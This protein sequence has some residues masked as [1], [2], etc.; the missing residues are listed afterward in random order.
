MAVKSATNGFV[1]KTMERY[2]VLGI[3]FVLQLV[4]ARILEPEVYGVVAIVLMFISFSNVFI[5]KGF[6]IALVQR[7]QVDDNDVSSVFW[8]S[9]II[10]SFFYS[11]IFLFAPLI[12]GFFN[13]QSLTGLLRVM[14][15]SLFPGVYSSIQE[16]ILRRNINFKVVFFA[17]ILSV[18]ISGG[19]AIWLAYKGFGVW[20]LA[21]QQL[22]YSILVVLLQYYQCRWQPKLYFSIQRIRYFWTF[23]WKVLITSL[24]DEIFVELRTLVIG[25]FY[26][27]TDLSFYNRG[28]QFP[29]LLINSINGSLQ[30]VLLPRFSS[31]QDD[32]KSMGE[33]LQKCVSTTY[34]VLLPLLVLLGCTAEQFVPLILTRKWMPCVPFLQLFCVYYACYPICTSC[35]QVLLAKGRSDIVMK[36]EITRKILDITVLIISFSFGAYY[37]A[38]GAVA[39]EV[40]SVP[41]YVLPVLKQVDYSFKSQ[42][43]EL[44]PVFMFSSVIAVISLSLAKLNIPLFLIL[45]LQCGISITFYICLCWI[46]KCKAQQYFIEYFRQVVHFKNR[47]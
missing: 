37:I 20:T 32:K 9:L 11:V 5:Q 42:I 26:A 41:L 39:V 38:L 25:K 14:S 17:S 7:K 8:F 43:V 10:A 33:L 35:A 44:F 34:F 21:V 12:A 18:G 16:A 24:V 47:K 1:W 22:L 46:F 23:G 29:N 2:G 31:I 3:Q 45:M 27:K 36:V 13:E 4:L 6:N 15:L 30:S 28:R 19:V 40:L